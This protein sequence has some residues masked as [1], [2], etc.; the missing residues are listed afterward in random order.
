MA[1]ESHGPFTVLMVVPTLK[2][3]H[4]IVNIN[5][6]I[7]ETAAAT[8]QIGIFKKNHSFCAK[9][10]RFLSLMQNVLVDLNKHMQTSHPKLDYENYVVMVCAI[11]AISIESNWVFLFL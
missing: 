7:T 5:K 6:P 1:T 8:L 9:G 4:C 11:K 3:Q 10:D 2:T